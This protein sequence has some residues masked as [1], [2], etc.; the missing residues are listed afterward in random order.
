MK[1]LC[2]KPK[3]INNAMIGKPYCHKHQTELKLKSEIYFKEMK[4]GKG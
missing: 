1:Q 2:K 4:N 3:C